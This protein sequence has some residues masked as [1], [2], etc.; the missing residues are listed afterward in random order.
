MCI[1]CAHCL[2][3]RLW[4]RLCRK[5]TLQVHAVMVSI[6]FLMQH[7][8]YFIPINSQNWNYATTCI[9]QFCFFRLLVKPYFRTD[10][11]HKAVHKWGLCISEVSLLC[12]SRVR[13]FI[14]RFIY[15][16]SSLVVRKVH[17]AERYCK[18]QKAEA[19]LESGQLQLPSGSVAQLARAWQANYQVMGSTDC[20]SFSL[21]F[22]PFLW[23]S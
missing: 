7:W 1:L 23:P 13:S 22:S 15:H 11:R 9:F 10:C 6:V 4:Y 18:G 16:F 12:H 8:T 14:L 20:Q 3:S 17:V 5:K 21:T 2:C 19:S